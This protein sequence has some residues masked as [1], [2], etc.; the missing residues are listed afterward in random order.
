METEKISLTDEAIRAIESL[1]HHAGVANFYID[2]L[3]KLN[4]YILHMSEEM[5][6]S[7][8]EAM[9]TLRALHMLALDIQALSIRPDDEPETQD[10]PDKQADELESTEQ[11]E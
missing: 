6:M 4:N 5:G 8:N 3:A 9:S 11:Q 7:D 2:T 10:D 1:Q